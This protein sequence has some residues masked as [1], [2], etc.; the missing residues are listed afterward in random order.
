MFMTLVEV[1]T[2]ASS[3]THNS[4]CDTF[5]VIWYLVKKFKT[6]GC[7][8]ILSQSNNLSA[9][10]QLLFWLMCAH[11]SFFLWLRV[12]S[13]WAFQ[14]NLGTKVPQVSSSHRQFLTSKICGHSTSVLT[15]CMSMGLRIYNYQPLSQ[16]I[17]N[18]WF[19]VLSALQAKLSFLSWIFFL[20]HVRMSWKF[21]YSIY[22]T[23]IKV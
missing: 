2:L 16:C 22:I 18:W 15:V 23:I 20:K 3:C 11:H 12:Q 19:C 10:Y 6:F 21:A 13:H 9:V 1:L 8:S 5:P 4:I 14:T 17:F 7:V